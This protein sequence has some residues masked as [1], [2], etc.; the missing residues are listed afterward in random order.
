MNDRNTVSGIPVTLKVDNDATVL[1]S[2]ATTSNAGIVTGDVSVGA[3]R[4]IVYSENLGGA[5][6]GAEQESLWKWTLTGGSAL[7]FAFGASS[8]LPIGRRNRSLP[9][10]VAFL[11]PRPRV[12]RSAPIALP[13]LACLRL[14]S[15]DSL[16]STTDLQP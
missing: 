4:T 2:G 6:G 13:M 1:V 10:S 16:S 12:G 3:N 11:S 8:R 5:F 9:R 14:N 7:N 15:G